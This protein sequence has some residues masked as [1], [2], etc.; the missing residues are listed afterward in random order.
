MRVLVVSGIW[1]PDVGG[2][3]SHAPEVASFLAARGHDVRV[4][5]TAAAAPAPESYAVH[6][7]SRRL[8]RGVLHGRTVAEIV[9]R[10]RGA[11]VCYS[12]GMFGRSSAGAA[13]A[14]R[15][16]VLKLTADPAYERARRLGAFSGS[17]EEFQQD[18]S[19][20]TLPF[21]LARDAAVRRAAHVCCPSRFLAD[22]AI[23]WGVDPD[24]VSVLP[25][26]APDA[27]GLP[28]RD[29]AR[30]EL[31]F[32]RPT[33]VTAG[34]LTAQ[35]ALDVGLAAVAQVDGFDL[36]VAGD[37]PERAALERR[38]AELGLDGRVRFVGPQPRRRVLELYR[39]ADGALLSSVWENFPH[40]VVEALAAGTPVVATDVGGVAEVVEDGVNGL[41][42]PPGDPGALA[43]AL[44]RY[45]ED[46]A[47]RARLRAGAPGSVER[48]SA[49][50]VFG[51]LEQILVEA[52]R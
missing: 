47:L 14:R 26:P 39:A 8:P 49:E 1:P 41:L 3:A 46:E 5:V 24:R 15:P 28:D 25:N 32:E 29:R 51:R 45:L 22:L 31:G 10:L 35:K 19:V 52:A 9:R 40:A 34:R 23:G 30:A 43:A 38:A 4:L 12:T 2:P 50:R 44:R 18:R 17:L 27:S 20:A 48:Y 6:W 36:V 33:I 42:V 7:V 16:I 13:L 21:R 37:G 11:D